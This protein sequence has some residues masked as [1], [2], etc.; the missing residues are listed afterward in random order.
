MNIEFL[1]LFVDYFRTLKH[2]RDALADWLFPILIGAW[3]FIK[4][5]ESNSLI[6]HAKELCSS[7]LSLLG[8]LLGFS[9]AITTL[10]ISGTSKNL[11]EIKEKETKILI[12]GKPISLFNLLL[13]NYSYSVVVEAILI[14]VNIIV[15]IFIDIHTSLSF[16]NIIISINTTLVSHILFLTIRNTT[17]FYFIIFKDIKDDN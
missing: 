2:R 3:V 6:T 14:I 16:I 9:I 10:L 5:I 13:I 8:V 11:D 4:N 7:Y 15:P 1:I 12:S 17:N